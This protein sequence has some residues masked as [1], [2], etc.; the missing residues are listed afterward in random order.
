PANPC[1][2]YRLQHIIKECKRKFI[3]EDRVSSRDVS[4]SVQAV[5]TPFPPVSNSRVRFD[6]DSASDSEVPEEKKTA[7]MTI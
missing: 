4:S 2:K 3:K 1:S 6:A 7:V 5:E